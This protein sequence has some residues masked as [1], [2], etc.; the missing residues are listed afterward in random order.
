MEAEKEPLTATR[1]LSM[2]NFLSAVGKEVEEG[3]ARKDV[4]L[5]TKIKLGFHDFMHAAYAHNLFA[6]AGL[7]V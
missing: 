4:C 5:N 3:F 1:Q 7:D 6:K 2:R